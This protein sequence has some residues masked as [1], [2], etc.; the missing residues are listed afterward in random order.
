[1]SPGPD[2]IIQGALDRRNLQALF[3]ALPLLRD[4]D[5]QQLRDISTEIEWFSLPGGTTLFEAGPLTDGLYAVVNGALGIYA[6][7]VSGGPQ[8]LGQIGGGETVG[9][10]EVISGQPRGATVIALRDT[11]VARLPIKS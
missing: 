3:A 9:E 7:R 11:E 1:M 2:T 8:Y 5:A 6:S 10:V 4:L